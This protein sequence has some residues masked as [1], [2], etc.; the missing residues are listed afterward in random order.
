M[1]E[2]S[3]LLISIVGIAIIFDYVNGMHDAANA[4][5]TTVATRALSPAVAV[6]IAGTLNFVGA[7]L[8]EGVAKTVSN[9]ILNTDTNTNQA[10][11]LA[12]LVGAI[13][14]NLF[15][16]WLGLPSS[17]SH[18]LIGGLVGA[19]AVAMGVSGVNWMGV[20]KKVLIP[21][22]LSPLL[23]FTLGYLIMVAFL[24]IFRKS[25]PNKVNKKFR[26]AQVGSLCFMA[27][28]H[29][30]NDAQKAMGIITLALVTA[31]LQGDGHI[32]PWVKFACASAI[33][34][35]TA[36]GGWRIIKTLGGKMVKLQPINAFAAELSSSS[37]LM[38]TAAFGMP[39]STTHVISSSIMG[40][41]ATKRL[42]AIRWNVVKNILIA[43]VFT[44]PAAALVAGICFLA[45][46]PIGGL[47]ESITISL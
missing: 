30:S 42:S 45:L 36:A 27:L 34:L 8:F 2:I 37:I 11:I 17:S 22:V 15:T 4:I 1:P 29:G 28:S 32:Q 14:W 19:G 44:L 23:G 26:L 39:V 20:V 35:G 18:A 21:G 24:W 12:A 33:A 40:V 43:W 46:D 10:I 38:G 31:G 13:L 5:A 9:G 41:G 6:I 3:L 16:W 25:N 47:L 7:F